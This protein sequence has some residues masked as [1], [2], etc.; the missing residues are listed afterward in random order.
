MYAPRTLHTI[1]TRS[2]RKLGTGGGDFLQGL[3][4][5]WLAS[6]EYNKDDKLYGN[7]WNKI[8]KIYVIKDNLRNMDCRS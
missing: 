3:G 6:L 7:T 1:T 4:T 8:E 2:V 5:A